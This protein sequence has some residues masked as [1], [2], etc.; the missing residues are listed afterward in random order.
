MI[1]F[2]PVV[3]AGSI[4]YGW[5]ISD[6]YGTYSIDRF[7]I[8]FRVPRSWWSLLYLSLDDFSN[9]RAVE[10]FIA[11]RFKIEVHVWQYKHLHVELWHDGDIDAV[12]LD[13]NPNKCVGND[14]F[15]KIIKSLSDLKTFTCDIQR[16]DYAY[17]I[18]VPLS[19]IYVLSRKQESF[20]KSTRYYGAPGSNGRLRV[21]DKRQERLDK[22]KIDIGEEVTRIEWEQRGTQ[23]LIFKFD[24]FCVADFPK[25]QYPASVIPFIDPAQINSAFRN[26]DPKTRKKYKDLLK[27]YPFDPCHFGELFDLYMSDYKLFDYRWNYREGRTLGACREDRLYPVVVNFDDMET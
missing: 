17:D 5:E 14:L 27:P 4:E 11:H 6:C 2:K 10:S 18:K 21:Y 13:F 19:Q 25:L 3:K 15:D 9:R 23:D 7:S 1:K 26:I 22:V 20:F 24:Q 12:K 8:L 16:V